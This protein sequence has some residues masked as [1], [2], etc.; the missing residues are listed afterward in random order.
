M[1]N[2]K[3]LVPS[4]NEITTVRTTRNIVRVMVLVTSAIILLGAGYVGGVKKTSLEYESEVTRLSSANET[5]SPAPSATPSSSPTP[6]LDIAKETE[7]LRQKRFAYLRVL[8]Q[9]IDTES[10]QTY[11]FEEKGYSIKLPPGWRRTQDDEITGGTVFTKFSE[12][13]EKKYDA[14]RKRNI[15]Q[16]DLEYDEFYSLLVKSMYSEL[17]IDIQTPSE[18]VSAKKDS[19]D[20]VSQFSNIF[21]DKIYCLRILDD[22]IPATGGVASLAVYYSL[23]DQKHLVRAS[24]NSV[25]TIFIGDELHQAQ[26]AL[27][28]LEK[29]A[30]ITT[31]E[32][33]D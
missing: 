21:R 25:P 24:F 19:T 5:T 16:P 18:Y 26:T 32:F 14:L 15:Q 4:T 13:E 31:L 1:F 8:P 11:S 30:I 17:Q 7:K 12:E 2:D 20:C 9:D 33:P 27:D 3:I 10:W 29:L 6:V 23:W 28:E 22:P